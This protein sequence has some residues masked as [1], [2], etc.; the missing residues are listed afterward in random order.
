[1]P[2][3]CLLLATLAVLMLAALDWSL[4]RLLP[5]LLVLV[6]MAALDLSLSPFLLELLAVVKL[7]LVLFLRVAP[8]G[9]FR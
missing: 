4:S 5:E 8:E 1:M 2:L 7:V 6:R 3:F 9:A